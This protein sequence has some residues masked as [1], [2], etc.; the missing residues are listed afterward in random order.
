MPIE[1][2]RQQRDLE[3]L[4]VHEEGIL[5]QRLNS[6][7]TMGDNALR[8]T[9]ERRRL[10]INAYK[11]QHEKAK[12][13]QN[14]SRSYMPLVYTA[15]E[16]A[17]SRLVN[18]I[19]PDD[20][21]VFAIN[22]ETED[23]T[24]GCEMMS[25]Y[26]KSIFKDIEVNETLSKAIKMVLFGEAALKTYIRKDV[27]EYTDS[28]QQMV[29]LPDG[30]F[31][32][33]VIPFKQEETKYYGVHAEIIN[34]DDYVF[35][36]ISGDI[37]K[38]TFV[39]RVW[40]YKDELVNATYEDGTP[41]YVNVEEIDVPDSKT[42]LQNKEIS[43]THQQG[44]EVKEYWIN[45]IE[46]EGKVYRDMIATVVEDR[47]IIRFEPNYYDYGLKPFIYCPFID[48]FTSEGTLQNV[49][50]GLCDRGYELQKITNFT[51]NQI[52]DESKI[53]LYGFWKYTP[54]KN[55][56]PAS[57]I[58]RPG[59]LVKVG[60]I[61]NLQPVINN[62]L[63][64]LSFGVTE[65]QYLED[66]FET[67]VG[68][69]KFLTGVLDKKS[70]NDTAT[71]KRLAA[72]GSDTR[73]RSFAKRIDNFLIK[74][75]VLFSYVS[76]RQQAMVDV[77]FLLDMARR[78]QKSRVKQFNPLSGQ[79]ETY[80]LND[81]QLIQQLPSIPPLSKIDINIVG[82]ENVLRKSEKAIQ[83]ERFMNGISQFSQFNPQTMMRVKE[84]VAINNYARYLSIDGDMIRTDQELQDE[85]QRRISLQRVGFQ[86]AA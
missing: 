54:D 58:A 22:G 73:F 37:T 85:Q 60:D 69:P 8:P 83:M 19:L 13:K 78:T 64:A 49:G 26:L 47:Y 50:H 86:Q 34:P 45:R 25:E 55:F 53:R 23:D 77:E 9:R 76:S 21:E 79:E 57:F 12:L 68:V 72:E 48:E 52:L 46:I 7:W 3:P 28:K 16:T 42:T 74:P 32:L 40:R 31:Q 30:T 33:G 24:L 63:S 20:E 6:V 18:S 27:A 5:L 35:F 65:L 17:H 43:K 84:N 36:P 81:T 71:A 1:I 66:K 41:V 56:N 4:S 75:F 70:G 59:G 62:H 11:C 80:E 44:L 15:I 39:H 61:N 51:M 2:N 10:L 29:P 82:F 67:V 38:A 14:R